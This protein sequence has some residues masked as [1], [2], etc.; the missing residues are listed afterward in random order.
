MDLDFQMLST[1]GLHL[2]TALAGHDWGAISPSRSA[3]R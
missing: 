3:G 1:N 2:H